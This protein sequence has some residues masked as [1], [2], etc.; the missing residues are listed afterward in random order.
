MAQLLNNFGKLS[1][2]KRTQINSYVISN[3]DKS[4]IFSGPAGIGKTYL[5]KILFQGIRKDSYNRKFGMAAEE[6]QNDITSAANGREEFPPLSSQ[7]LRTEPEFIKWHLFLDDIDKIK[8]TEF[9]EPQFKSLIDTVIRRDDQLVL[10]T[11]LMTRVD[12]LKKLGDQLGRRILG[13]CTWVSFTDNTDTIISPA[14]PASPNPIS[15]RYNE[16]ADKLVSE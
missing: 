1:P 4:Y 5:S 7:Y 2:E 13:R 14:K 10:T 11:S 9:I 6:W 16:E 12:L 15:H 8:L 3:P